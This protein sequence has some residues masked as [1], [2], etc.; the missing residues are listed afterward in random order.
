MTENIS[1]HV[2]GAGAWGTALANHFA[3][4]MK[5][6]LQVRNKHMLAEMVQR[7]ESPRLPGVTLHE[8]LKLVDAFVE[9]DIICFALPFSVLREFLQTAPCLDRPLVVASKGITEDGLLVP[10]VLEQNGILANGFLLSGPSFARDLAHGRPAAVTLA[11]HSFASTEALAHCL[12]NTQLRVYPDDDMRGVALGGAVKNV[13]AMACGVA[14]GGGL[15]ESAVAAV[16]ARGF[17]EIRRLADVIGARPSTMMGLSGFGDLFLTASSLTSRNTQFGMALGSGK[18]VDQ[19]MI[20]VFGIVE[21]RASINGV[22]AL[23]EK[24]DLDLPIT[25]GLRDLLL[26]KCSVQELLDSFRARP[27]TRE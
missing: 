4:S 26:A 20:S 22:L 8:Q 21:G 6:S 2:V 13:M 7:Q 12:H 14:R 11:G 18:T 9:A 19:A 27:M 16:A 25:S 10:D 1:M 17:A 24:Y 3:K 5:T 15:G 23:A